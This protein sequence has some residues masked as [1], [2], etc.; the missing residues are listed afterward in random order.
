MVVVAEAA[1]WLLAPARPA[2]GPGAGRRERLL[3]PRGARARRGLPRAASAAADR[4]A[5]RSRARV[6][7]AVAFGRPAPLRRAAR[8]ARRAPAARAPPPPARRSRSLTAV[9]TLPVSLVSHERAVDVG[10]STQSLGL[11]ALGRRPARPGS[12]RVI[13]AGGAALLIALVRRFPRRWWIPG[14]GG[15]HRARRASSPGSRPV[16]LAPIFNQLR[17]A[18]GR[19]P[20]AR[21]DVLELGRARRGRHRR[22][23]PDRRQPPGHRAE[24]LRRRDRLDQAG[25]PL[26]QP[27]RAGRAARAALGG[28]PRARPRRPRRHPP[29]APL[30][31]DRR[32][33]RAAVRARGGARDRPPRRRRP[34]EP[35]RG[36]G[37]PA[38]AHAGGV[39][40]QRPRQP[41]L[42]QDRGERRRV[43][44][45]A[46]R[47]PR[48]ADRPPGAARAHQ[49]LRP[50]SAGAV[51]AP[52]SAPTRRPSSGSAP[53]SPTRTSRR[54]ARS[55]A[56]G[57]GSRRC[58]AAAG[59]RP[60]ATSW[61]RRGS[62]ASPSRSS[63]TRREDPRTC[64]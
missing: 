63:G 18:A 12:P 34:G 54:P 60:R 29:R 40:A 5:W 10:L 39:R 14:A 11:L 19:Q 55:R 26:R 25:R 21:A 42:A 35:G 13:T 52:C 36:P 1:V 47:R 56:G 49:P 38:R 27:A 45:R 23:L 58:G 30:R 20:G 31:R 7:V 24:R 8:P 43:R 61:R 33:A 3:Q 64:Q 37:L 9:V 50:R 62:R 44:A 32:P 46:H 16:V 6:L 2:A 4:R 22:G 57:R 51:S 48:G 41:A 15:R 28:R 53:R 59:R 17:A